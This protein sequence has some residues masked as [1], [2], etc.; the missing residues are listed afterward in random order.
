[1]STAT[2]SPVNQVRHPYVERKPGVGGGKPVIVGTRIKVTQVA[3]EY[4]RLGWTA[5]QIIDAHPHLTLAQ[6]HD[7]LSYYYENQAALDADILADE[8]TV[9]EL[10]QLYPSKLP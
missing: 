8:Q 3:I 1:M 5:D 2:L 6:V 10:S 4:E 7:A 9:A